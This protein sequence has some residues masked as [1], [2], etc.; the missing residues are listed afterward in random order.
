[1][2]AVPDVNTRDILHWKSGIQKPSVPPSIDHKRSLDIMLV[3]GKKCMHGKYIRV[4]SQNVFQHEPKGSLK[5][6]NSPEDQNKAHLVKYHY[7]PSYIQDHNN[8]RRLI[9]VAQRNL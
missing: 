4:S 8:S 5:L 7:I 1:M 6:G 2:S 9:G 3:L